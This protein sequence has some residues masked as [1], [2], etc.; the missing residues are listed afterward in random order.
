MAQSIKLLLQIFLLEILRVLPVPLRTLIPVPL[1]FAARVPTSSLAI[2]NV[3]V[4][5][6][7]T[8]ANTVKAFSH[9]FLSVVGGL[10]E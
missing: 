10:R 4:R 1:P 9:R 3:W 7:P 8:A 2:F 5:D 6:E